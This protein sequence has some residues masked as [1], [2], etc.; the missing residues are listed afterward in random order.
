[1]KFLIGMLIWEA[2]SIAALLISKPRHEAEENGERDGYRWTGAVV[3]FGGL[4]VVG[5]P[6]LLVALT[7]LASS[8]QLLWLSLGWAVTYAAALRIE[9]MNRRE[10]SGYKPVVEPLFPI[11]V[12]IFLG[13]FLFS[14]IE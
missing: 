4:I 3:I 7:R 13:L 8:A 1:M 5:T 6:V 11:A 14:F 10:N 2:V 12:V 9:V